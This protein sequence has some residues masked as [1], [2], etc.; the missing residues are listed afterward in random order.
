[1]KG[2]KILKIKI[3]SKFP[4]NCTVFCFQK[5]KPKTVF[6]FPSASNATHFRNECKRDVKHT[7]FQWEGR[8]PW[9][10]FA[11]NVLCEAILWD[12]QWVSP[13]Q[14]LLHQARIFVE[15]TKIKKSHGIFRD[16]TKARSGCSQNVGDILH[17]LDNSS[18]S[19][20]AVGSRPLAR[21][22]SV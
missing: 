6:H 7:V 5:R 8:G 11:K 9:W 4:T 14:P 17:S 2:Q 21:E 16:N 15:P 12:R 3:M 19:L 20:E 18:G 13:E 22:K 1:M 10:G